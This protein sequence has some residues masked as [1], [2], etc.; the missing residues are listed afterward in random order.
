M[1]DTDIEKEIQRIVAEV[2]H[3]AINHTLVGL[4]IVKE[5]TEENGIAKITFAFPFPN[6][7]IKDQLINSVVN[8][9]AQHDI[10]A[11]TSI[12]I[13]TQDELNNF[14]ALE[15]QNWVGGV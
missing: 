13:M 4:G 3:P 15:K 5:V 9:L 2:K 14:L 7:P 12:V 10:K 1:T 8:A 6:I 11:E